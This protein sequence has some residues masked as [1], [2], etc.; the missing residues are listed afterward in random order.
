MWH[1][2]YGLH[3]TFADYVVLYQYDTFFNLFKG[4][5]GRISIGSFL[6]VCV[7]C[8]DTWLELIRPINSVWIYIQQY[9]FRP[10]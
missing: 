10:D 1:Y 6:F 2:D 8:S 4:F 3:A 7:F 5:S 9:T